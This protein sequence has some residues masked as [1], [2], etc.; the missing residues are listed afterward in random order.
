MPLR[1]VLFKKKMQSLKFTHRSDTDAVFH[2][3][4]AIFMEKVTTCKHALFSHVD[5]QR[6]RDLVQAL[7]Y[8]QSMESFTLTNFKCDSK[9]LM[10]LCKWLKDR[11][12]RN[13]LTEIVIQFGIENEDQEEAI[14]RAVAEIL[15]ENSSLTRFHLNIAANQFVHRFPE[16]S[17]LYDAFYDFEVALGKNRTLNDV[18]LMGEEWW[19]H[20][21]KGLYI[22]RVSKYS[23]YSTVCRLAE[24]RKRAAVKE[25]KPRRALRPPA[26]SEKL[27]QLL[28]QNSARSTDELWLRD[29]GLGPAG[30]RAM[31]G[32]LERNSRVPVNTIDLSFNRI[33]DL[34]AVALARTIKIQKAVTSIDL[35]DNNIGDAGAVAFADA[36]DFNTTVQEINLSENNIGDEGAV[37]LANAIKAN[38]NVQ[39][40]HLSKNNIGDAGAVALAYAMKINRT[41][42]QIHLSNKMIG[43]DGA[44]ALAD[45]LKTNWAV[46]QIHLSNTMISDD[47]AVALAD[48]IK[49][50]KAMTKIDLSRNGYIGKV[51]K[52]A[53]REAQQ[54]NQSVALYYWWD[55]EILVSGLRSFHLF[56]QR[57]C[58]WEF[59]MQTL[60]TGSG[61]EWSWHRPLP[62][63]QMNL[64]WWFHQKTPALLPSDTCLSADDV[65]CHFPH[66]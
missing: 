39:Q 40:I 51:G 24:L 59:Y 31:A 12:K 2:L 5:E 42:Q 65:F 55:S 47:G 57:G 1:P 4:Q 36:L 14:V 3:Q 32:L 37:A 63:C 38:R 9:S 22:D 60:K 66:S 43:D 44:V 13:A 25:E 7:P 52:M 54:V 11:L 64:N 29:L 48:A 35:R 62:A 50:N 6:F 21:K 8:Y 16:E 58:G 30:A 28:Q 27:V 23:F 17:T 61:Q 46:Q 10:Q 56:P 33:G 15:P 45:A 26:M 18:D 41:V 20:W 19:Q 53:L 34:G 49:I